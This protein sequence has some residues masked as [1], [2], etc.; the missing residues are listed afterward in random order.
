MGSKKYK[1]VIEFLFYSEIIGYRFGTE[2][3]MRLANDAGKEMS[4]KMI[5]DFFYAMIVEEYP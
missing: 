1:D 4:Y 2:Q 5:Y 3:A